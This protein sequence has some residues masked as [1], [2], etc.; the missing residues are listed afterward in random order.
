MKLFVCVHEARNLRAMDLNGF[1]DPYVRLQLGKYKFK[2]KVVKKCLNPSW[3]EEFCFRVDDLNEEL[4]VSV[5]DED[6]YFNHDFVGQLKIPVLRVFELE[7]KTLGTKWYALQ[8]KNKKS[9]HKDCGEIL[10][11][12]A[13]SQSNVY[14]D[15][16]SSSNGDHAHLEK[17]THLNN[18]SF[19]TPLSSPSMSGMNSPL[20]SSF[21]MGAGDASSAKEEKS[22]VQAFASLF[23]QIFHKGGDNKTTSGSTSRDISEPDLPEMQNPDSNGDVAN[24]NKSEEHSSGCTFDEGMKKLQANDQGGDVPSNLPGGTV[25]DKSFAVSPP[26]LNSLLFSPD[27]NFLRSLAELQGTTE[28]QLGPWKFEN[29]GDSFKRVVTY[30]KAPTRLIKALKATEEHTYLKADG[31]VFAVL[32]SVSTPEVVYGNCFKVEVLYCIT[33]G[34]EL[35]TG[36]ESSR[37]TVSWRVNFLQNTIMKGM[38]E[39]GA[40][41]GLK[42]SFEQFGDLLS[43]NVR[44]IDPKDAGSTKDQALASL[45]V[46]P[47][48]YWKLA[49]QYFLNFTVFSTI[50]MGLYVLAHICLALPSTIQGLE[51]DGLDLPDSI[52]EVIVCGVLVLQGER[53]FE[54]IAR[55]M[56]ARAQRGSDHGVKAQGN[57]WLLTVALIEGSRLA[58]VDSTG[59]SDPYVVFTCNGKTKTSSIKFQKLDPQWN[60]IFEFDAMDEPPSTLD[61]EVFDFDGPFYEATS[62]GHAEINFVKSN[63]SDLADVWIPLQ[64]KLAQACQSKLHLR[65]FLNNTSGNNIVKDYLTKMEKEVGKK[66][67]VRS[68]QTNSAFQKLFVLPP[69]EFLI[70][71]F[72]CHL[73]RKMLLQGR[74]FLSARIFGFH[75]NLFGHRT[76]F[77]FLW[78]DVEDIQVL[79]PTFATMGSPTIVFT[80][81]RGRGMDA[82]HGAK[83]Q[84]EEGRLKFYF[85]TFVSFNVAH[86]TIMALWRAR[87]L[88]LEQKVRIIEEET[89][90]KDLQSEESG[91]FLVLEDASMSEAFSSILPVPMNFFMELFNGGYLDRT[92]MEKVGCLDYSPTPWELVKPDVH[93]RQVSYKFDK[94]I[95]RY[96]GEVTSTQQRS[97]LPDGNGWVVEEVMTLHGIPMGD[98]F[99]LHIRYQ[100]E[101]MPSRSK[102]CDV[103]VYFGIAWLKSTK[104]QKRLSKNIVSNLVDRLKVMFSQIEKEFEL[105]K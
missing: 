8:P 58:A 66:I 29:N 28:L 36:G 41:Q 79:N 43:Q 84:D 4:L 3:I 70:N 97:P 91:S 89:E 102:A 56:Q 77:F 39:G 54:M 24:G 46:E 75:A 105:V 94:H 99:T 76:K 34:P 35:P 63:I 48:S 27:S 16:D 45:Q 78:E 90:E 67:N 31:K 53:A 20:R 10:L 19:S 51:F 15:D 65:V 100:V 22:G 103:H 62:L 104:H 64:G 60:E 80:L 57:G 9:K 83:T 14:L 85:H 87:S 32:S 44:L 11:T 13:L 50:L 92:V 17:L 96:R 1:S 68:P 40:R 38:I 33:P 59:F 82:K 37:L 26:D 21:V 101:D 95:S 86:R 30:V 74:V 23:A 72:T 73:K 98:Y 49:T 69:E 12:I 18:E 6:K 52:G 71:D 81:R 47:Q 7:S 93:Q 25:L 55:F 42:D 2:T 5:M 61:M 88:S